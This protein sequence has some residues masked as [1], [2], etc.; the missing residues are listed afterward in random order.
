MSLFEELKSSFVV[1][2]TGTNLFNITFAALF[3]VSPKKFN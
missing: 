2:L 3:K 1:G